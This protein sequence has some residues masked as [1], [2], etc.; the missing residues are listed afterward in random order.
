VAAITFQL[1]P[2]AF[3]VCQVRM[4]TTPLVDAKQSALSVRVTP[5]LI[6]CGVNR[7]PNAVDWFHADRYDVAPL[8]RATDTSATTAVATDA[9]TKPTAA[10]AAAAAAAALVPAASGV[11]VWGGGALVCVGDVATG[12]CVAT[13]R[14]HSPTARVHAVRCLYSPLFTLSGRTAIEL[15]T[16]G[17]DATILVWRFDLT[18]LQVN[19]FVAHSPPSPL[20]PLCSHSINLRPVT[21]VLCEL[22]STRALPR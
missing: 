18:T 10:P 2:N 13:L 7:D 3:V 5:R 9:K 4:S 16:A 17:S 14:G 22:D 8:P 20:V 15:V 6:A 19:T 11:L 12:V 1:T 21:C